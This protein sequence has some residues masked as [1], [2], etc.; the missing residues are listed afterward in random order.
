MTRTSCCEGVFF[1]L[2]YSPR[3]PTSNFQ[4]GLCGI[5]KEKEVTFVCVCVC[6]S[7]QVWYARKKKNSDALWYH[8]QG[9]FW[10]A[11]GVTFQ[12]SRD[13]TRVVTQQGS[14]TSTFCNPNLDDFFFCPPNIPV[15]HHPSFV[16]TTVKTVTVLAHSQ[17]LTRNDI[18]LIEVWLISIDVVKSSF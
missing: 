6:G 9:P 17:R 3:V 13:E 8:C 14:M 12:S 5:R 10:V 1:P 2:E 4:S 16:A 11:Q 7:V 15:R 18:D